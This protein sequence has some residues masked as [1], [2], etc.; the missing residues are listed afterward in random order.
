MDL[1][2]TKVEN[3]DISKYKLQTNVRR[4]HEIK[5]GFEKIVFATDQDLDGFHIRGLL[6]GF[7]HKYLPE[8]KDKIGMLQTPVIVISKN[9]KIKTWMYNLND[10]VDIE[11]GDIPDYKK[12][13]GSWDV[14]DLKY[15]ISKD[16][17]DK[18]IQ[19]IDFSNCDEII[20]EWLGD[21]SQPRKK[22]II[23][24][25]FNIAKA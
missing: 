20:D 3:V 8:F 9:G 6:S 17:V 19:H 16:G 22:Y 13:L 5:G 11:N 1:K 23:N 2:F 4:L 14:E 12:G 24:N 15:I 25:D 7:I 18:M 21:D 10:N